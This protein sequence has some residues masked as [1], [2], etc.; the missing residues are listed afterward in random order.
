MAQ[1][2]TEPTA[3]EKQKLVY[4]RKMRRGS[5]QAI[6][7]SQKFAVCLLKLAPAVNQ[8]G[9]YAALKG[10]IVAVP[11]I[12]DIDLLVDGVTPASI[13]ENT[14]LRVVVEAQIRIDDLPPEEPLP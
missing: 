5:T 3:D 14:Q 13:P 2:L 11:G 10:A 6:D 1:T 4:N 9:D 12:Q 8:P 7:P